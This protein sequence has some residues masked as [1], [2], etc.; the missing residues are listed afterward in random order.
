MTSL[1]VASKVDPAAQ[2]ISAQ[3]R[4]LKNFQE[5]DSKDTFRSEDVY[6]KHVDTQGIYTDRL[7]VGFT[8][9]VVIFASKHRSEANEPALTV[10]W[11]GN[12][13]ARA[14]LGGKPKSLTNRPRTTPNGAA[15]VGLGS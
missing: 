1:V 2:T 4:R 9:D 13:T 3:L 8:P 10:H 14:D 12:P 5:S 6:L 11:T 15:G 7:D